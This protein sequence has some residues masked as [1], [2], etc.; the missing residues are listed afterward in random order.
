[1]QLFDLMLSVSFRFDI[2]TKTSHHFIFRF[3]IETKRCI[4]FKLS[5]ER[6]QNKTKTFKIVLNYRKKERNIRFFMNELFS[7]TI[8]RN[9][10]ISSIH[11]PFSS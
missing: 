4:L 5:Y 11:L 8:K 2:E 6:K 1:M 9:V 10:D 3:D 7:I